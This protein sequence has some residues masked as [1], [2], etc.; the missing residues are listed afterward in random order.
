MLEY[1]TLH[2]IDLGAEPQIFSYDCWS[3]IKCLVFIPKFEHLESHTYLSRKITAFW[4]G[5]RSSAFVA[6]C[7][8]FIPMFILNNLIFVWSLRLL[9]LGG[10]K[11]NTKG[12]LVGFHQHMCRNV[13]GFQQG[14][15]QLRPTRH[16][17]YINPNGT[18]YSRIE[19]KWVQ[20]M[21]SSYLERRRGC[22]W[23]TIGFSL[24][25][26]VCISIVQDLIQVFYG[27]MLLV[28]IDERV[29]ICCL[30]PGRRALL[31][32]SGCFM[33]ICQTYVLFSSVAW[34]YCHYW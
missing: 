19:A 8:P 3:R 11:G 20:H 25:A 14:I 31:I 17:L 6:L 18:L 34:N 9:H 30:V 5:V 26:F 4:K 15:W 24:Y 23:L 33:I 13:R 16:K 2:D 29:L 32:T 21:L 27:R 1:Q 7:D 10:Q 12:K 28:Q 22:L